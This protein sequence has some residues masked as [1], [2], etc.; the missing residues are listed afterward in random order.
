MKK[1]Y[2]SIIENHYRN[3]AEKHKMDLTS[4]MPDL[5]I[6]A[7]EIENILKYIRDG[8]KCFEVGCGNG[9]ASLLISK[10]RNIELLSVDASKE[11]IDL[12]KCQ[13]KS[14]VKG[15]LEFEHG[16][17]LN[18]N[19]DI[20]YDV[21]FT[22]RCIINL[23]DWEDQK[24]ALENLTKVVN[25]GG[26][27]VLLEAFSE[28]LSE[29][30]EARGELGLDSIPP[31]YHNLHLKKN[32]VVTHL[33]KYNLKLIEENNFLSSYYFGTRVLYPALAKANN[34]DIKYNSKIA[35]F[36]TNITSV[37]NFAHIKIL[38]FKKLEE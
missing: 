8:N 30:N 31:A 10:Q 12:A 37:G 36:F 22:I 29:L 11:M 21:V 38:V 32:D 2:R 15:L 14:G 27:L 4:T 26:T 3:Q 33:N 19:S 18:L 20:K 28:G 17:I 24:K 13:D 34:V 23:L 25:P 9:S 35:S 6:R 5:N 7:M 1:D 16:D